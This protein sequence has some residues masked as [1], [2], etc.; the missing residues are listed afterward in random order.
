MTEPLTPG[1]GDLPSEP[2]RD[3]L[4]LR[5]ASLDDRFAADPVVIRR[6]AEQSPAPPGTPN[7]PAPP[8]RMPRRVMVVSALMALFGLLGVLVS[9][10]LV[11]GLGAHG[12]SVRPA[13]YVILYTQLALSAT[14]V[15][16]VPFLLARRNWAR[17]LALTLCSLNIVGAVISLLTGNFAAIG[18]IALNGALIRA[19]R[20]DQVWDWFDRS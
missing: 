14:Q 16:V 13:L 8:P 18:A 12:E 10:A 1:R 6:P 9:W 2:A 3:P 20:N 4:R 19:L 7:A 5:F 11:S 15:G 17:V